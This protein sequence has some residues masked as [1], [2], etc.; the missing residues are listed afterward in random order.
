L[1][2][3]IAYKLKSTYPDAQQL[4]HLKGVTEPVSSQD[5]LQVLVHS[6][7]PQA[8]LPE[9]LMAFLSVARK[10]FQTHDADLARAVCIRPRAVNYSNSRCFYCGKLVRGRKSREHVFPGWLQRNSN[11]K[12]RTNASQRHDHLILEA[13][14]AVLRSLQQ[15][16]PVSA[17]KPRKPPSV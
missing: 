5:A 16:T 9:G 2:L 8:K 11:F 3:R 6:F 12:I 7:E 4:V 14:C 1:A 17:G 15:Y 10:N 13:H